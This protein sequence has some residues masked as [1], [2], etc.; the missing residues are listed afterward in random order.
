MIMSRYAVRQIRMSGKRGRWMRCPTCNADNQPKAT[1]CEK[2]GT[3]L[4]RK[5]RKRSMGEQLDSPFGPVGDGP[6][7]RALIAY[8]WAV[9]GM[10]PFVGL[11]AGPIAIA[12]GAHAWVCD[13]GGDG[14][15]AWGPLRAS[16]LLGGITA[17]ANW[18]GMALIVL[19]LR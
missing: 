18:V 10:I 13:R 9:I 14:F 17:L 2:C 19:G 16:L 6:N 8:R 4:P 1:T 7:R 15:S 11:V 12:L 5:P 3:G